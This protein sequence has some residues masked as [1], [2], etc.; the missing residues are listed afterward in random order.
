MFCLCAP[1]SELV[2]EPFVQECLSLSDSPLC[3]AMESEEKAPVDGKWREV[4]GLTQNTMGGGVCTVCVCVGGW[5]WV[6][7]CVC[8]WGGGCGWVCVQCVCVCVCVG[9][10][11][12]VGV[13][14]CG[15]GS[16]VCVCGCDV[17]VFVGVMQI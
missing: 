14:G 5:V 10:C 4:G 1:L 13:C 8:V 15:C 17:G 3:E 9:G 7:G 2:K 16:C 11:G 6:G 12:C